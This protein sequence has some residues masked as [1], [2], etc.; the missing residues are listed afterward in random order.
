MVY[1]DSL[2][3]VSADGFKF[4]QRPGAIEGFEKS[5]AFLSATPCD[6][7]LTP[8]AE[9]SMFWERVDARNKGVV[10]DPMIDSSA[11]RKLADRSREQLRKRIATETAH[12]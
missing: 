5:F 9:A 10:P 8:H 2:S 4:T 11:C 1:A 6:I 3:A 12:K 7:L